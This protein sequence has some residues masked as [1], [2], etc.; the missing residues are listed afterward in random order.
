MG[1]TVSWMVIK[2]LAVTANAGAQT[3]ERR[4]RRPAAGRRIAR[5]AAQRVALSDRGERLLEGA[6]EHGATVIRDRLGNMPADAADR[7][8]AHAVSS[9]QPQRLRRAGSNLEEG[10]SRFQ[11][12]IRADLAV[13]HACSAA[14]LRS[15][16]RNNDVTVRQ[17]LERIDYR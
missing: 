13:D 14:V 8:R 10:S 12:S 1:R 9:R 5:R 16:R 11:D 6:I 7:K 2:A 17:A 3:R 4:P 15:G